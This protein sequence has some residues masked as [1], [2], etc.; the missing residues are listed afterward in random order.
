MEEVELEQ[1]R[2]R[3]TTIV[4]IA[5]LVV[6]G[7]V[8]APYI[9][10]AVKGVIGLAIAAGVAVVMVNVAPVLADK[11]A[12][13]RL[14]AIKREAAKNP[15][16]TLQLDFGKRQQ[17]L[18]KFK[19]AITNFGAATLNFEDKL[20]SFKERFPKDSAKFES[21]LTKMKALLTIRK[22]KYGEAQDALE[23]FANEIDRAKA[24]WSMGQEAAKMNSAAGMTDDDFLS[25][26]KTETALDS[27]TTSMNSAFAELETS[28]DESKAEKEVKAL[29]E[30]STVTV[31]PIVEKIKV[32]R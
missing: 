1:K 14:A 2:K 25:K 16:E 22:K 26:I 31:E 4:K 8:V 29:T 3:I 13:W 23:Q 20:D 15:I 9:F 32:K 12:N 6:A 19:Q 11:L 28:L 24:I 10:L 17:A 30:G 21:Q 7:F 27:V 18:G 5:A